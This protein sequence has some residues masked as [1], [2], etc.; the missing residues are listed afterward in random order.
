MNQTKKIDYKRQGG[1]GIANVRRTLDL[2]YPNN[3]KLD[4]KEKDNWYTLKLTI[5][6]DNERNNDM[7]NC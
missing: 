7:Y 5:N 6:I 4:M 1:V 2:V 3:Y